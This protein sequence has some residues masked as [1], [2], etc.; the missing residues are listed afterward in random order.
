MNKI[1]LRGLHNP[2]TATTR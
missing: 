1:S 2:T